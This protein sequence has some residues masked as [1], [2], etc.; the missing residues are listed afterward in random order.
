M[1][2]EAGEQDAA[3]RLGVRATRRLQLL[4]EE[5]PTAAELLQPPQV[6]R[7]WTLQ[8]LKRSGAQESN[9]VRGRGGA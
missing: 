6:L 8:H 1:S 3:P 5:S 7:E 9:K 4:L 2:Q